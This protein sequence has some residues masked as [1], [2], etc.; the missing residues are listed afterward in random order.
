[1]ASKTPLPQ[2]VTE[3]EFI[4]LQ[5]FIL[6]YFGMEEPTSDTLPKFNNQVLFFSLKWFD[7]VPN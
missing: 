4:L 5:A 1:M 3:E 7:L 6:E 2:K